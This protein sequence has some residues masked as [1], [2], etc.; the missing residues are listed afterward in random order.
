[1]INTADAGEGQTEEKNENAKGVLIYSYL[2]KFKTQIN[3]RYQP[4]PHPIDISAWFVQFHIKK[5]HALLSPSISD[6]GES[7][8][9]KTC[10][11]NKKEWKEDCNTCWCEDGKPWCTQQICPKEPHNH[12]TTPKTPI[13][14]FGKR[15]FQAV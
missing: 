7:K 4:K 10:P 13:M 11:P 9:H 2:Y 12:K 1:M 3:S 15:H 6:Y 5:K 8:H 14:D